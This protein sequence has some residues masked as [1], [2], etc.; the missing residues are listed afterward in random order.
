MLPILVVI[1]TKYACNLEF[2]K[3]LFDPRR[4]LSRRFKNFGDCRHIWSPT[5]TIAGIY[6]PYRNW[7]CRHIRSSFEQRLQAYLVSDAIFIAGIFRPYLDRYCR[8]NRS[9]RKWDFE[10]SFIEGPVKLSLTKQNDLVTDL[11]LKVVILDMIRLFSQRKTRF[12]I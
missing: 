3:W 8:H 4:W 11:E 12:I 10:S 6:G 7:N 5:D 9:P 1:G 2:F